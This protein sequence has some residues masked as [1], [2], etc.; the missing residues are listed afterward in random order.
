[1]SVSN[2]DGL[3]KRRTVDKNADLGGN[4]LFLAYSGS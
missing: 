4:E 1:M 2:A 3:L